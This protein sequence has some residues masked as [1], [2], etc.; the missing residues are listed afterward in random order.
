VTPWT[1]QTTKPSS[2]FRRTKNKPITSTGRAPWSNPPLRPRGSLHRPSI[3]L[4]GWTLIVLWT[5]TSK[6][7]RSKGGM[8]TRLHT[9]A[10]IKKVS[11][12]RTKIS[13]ART[14]PQVGRRKRRKKS[15]TGFS[16]FSLIDLE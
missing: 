12:P 7:T 15:A 9:I 4:M 2:R 16:P 5:T 13:T 10:P 8:C 3:S 1:R 14:A 11:T 6:W